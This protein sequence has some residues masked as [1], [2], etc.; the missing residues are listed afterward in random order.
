MFNYGSI[1][2]FFPEILDYAIHMWLP[3]EYL[4]KIE[5]IKREFEEWYNDIDNKNYNY[6]IFSKIYILSYV[7][8]NKYYKYLDF[9]D[10]NYPNIFFETI[11]KCCLF[12]PEQ[13]FRY[14]LSR[15]LE[16]AGYVIQLAKN[17]DFID[18]NVQD[19]CDM[20]SAERIEYLLSMST[21]SHCNNIK[22]Q[23]IEKNIYLYD[24]KMY[25]DP[26]INQF[27]IS[28]DENTNLKLSLFT[29][30]AHK[31]YL[32]LEKK[33]QYVH[34]E[35]YI[36]V[37][38]NLTYED[39]LNMCDFNESVEMLCLGI[40]DTEK[41]DK[42]LKNNL[43][44]TYNRD[45]SEFININHLRDIILMIVN[46]SDMTPDI[47]YELLDRNVELIDNEYVFDFFNGGDLDPNKEIYYE[48]YTK[49]TNETAKNLLLDLF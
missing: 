24:Y 1:I 5:E 45:K 40:F 18:I 27:I 26:D 49:L 42:H 6:D 22:K 19:Y 13:V 32:E 31:L 39:I 4:K 7:D 20:M 33:S 37:K 34:E 17:K 21:I 8:K 47:L 12:D 36:I 10:N 23:S 44:F 28:F 41:I 11:K 16:Y 9:L 29:Y 3:F 2:G 43:L 25:V 30:A 38:T 35:K 15:N 14:L 46:N 48:I